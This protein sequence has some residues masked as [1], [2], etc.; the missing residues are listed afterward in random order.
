[1]H[2]DSQVTGF[3]DLLRMLKDVD[4]LRRIRFTTSHPKDLSPELIEC[5]AEMDK[6]CS[7]IHLPFQAGSN[8]VLMA[9]NRGY[10]RKKYLE[11]IER[12]RE[13]R[14]DMAVS[15]DVM[16]GFPGESREDFELTLDLIERVQFDGLYSFKYS[17]REGTRAAGLKDK[18]PEQ[19]KLERLSELQRLQKNITLKKNEQMLGS[20]VEILVEGRSRKANQLAGRSSSNKIVN[21]ACDYNLIGK[22]INV[23]IK[24]A[25]ANSLWGE[26]SGA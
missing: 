8:R 23:K 22:L 11:L 2:Y 17:D 19:E 15:S 9:M 4:G 3:V 16:V 18:V 5:F 14:A 1:M 13:V 25:Y 12:L 26:I 7:H 21:F 24:R 20:E 6:L 10:T